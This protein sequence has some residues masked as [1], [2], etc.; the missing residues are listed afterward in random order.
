MLGQT[1]IHTQIH[2]ILSRIDSAAVAL[3]LARRP[4]VETSTG[5]QIQISACK[6]RFVSRAEHTSQGKGWVRL[7][8]LHGPAVGG[9]SIERVIHQLR[10]GLGKVV[11]IFTW[12][13]WVGAGIEGC[14]HLVYH[15]SI[16]TPF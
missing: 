14:A 12:L 3:L 6:K 7:I 13:Q 5:S 1:Y 9:C 2:S 4:P 11:N 10:E 15:V 8:L 16:V